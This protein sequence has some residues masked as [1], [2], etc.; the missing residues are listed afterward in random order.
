[1]D[2]M[3]K[4]KGDSSDFYFRRLLRSQILAL[5][6]YSMEQADGACDLVRI[7]ANENC[8]GTPPAVLGALR[9]LLSGD[10]K[11]NRYP[12]KT[13][14]ALRNALA[15]KYDLP[16]EYFVVGNGLDDIINM[17]ALTFLEPYDDVIIPAAAFGVYSET[18]RMMGANVITVPMKND[19]SINM[20]AMVD[21]VTS[22]TKM[23]FLCSPNN[24]TGTII[25]AS[26]FD[27]FLEELSSLPT[28]PLI[29]MD[30]A[31]ID[32][33][34][35]GAGCLNAVKYVRHYSNI[36]VMRTFSKISGIA[37]LRVGY[38]IAHPAMLTYIYRVRPPFTV[39]SLAQA[40]ALVDVTD[41]S[42]E[43]FRDKARESIWEVKAELEKFLKDRGVSYVPSHANFV[44]AFYD[45]TYVRLKKI[46]KELLKRDI[47]AR[48]LKHDHAPCGLRFSIGTPEENGRLMNA[49]DEITTKRTE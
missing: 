44:F 31:Y 46:Y 16:P 26:E 7:S 37:G 30:H 29:M 11:L 5:E 40:A 22:S 48:L 33:V 27:D 20:D 35:P 12:D 34:R 3:E 4:S 9:D 1:M 8:L 24:P 45:L 36:A 28:Q 21:A 41:K 13:C 2:R 18:A 49:L 32:F 19:L 25:S 38:L 6:G 39:N 47:L 43:A 14:G 42:A 17:L 10:A 15:E 23:I